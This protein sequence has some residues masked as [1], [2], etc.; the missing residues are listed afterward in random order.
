V[1][2]CRLG[3]RLDDLGGMKCVLNVCSVRMAR[4]NRLHE[5]MSLHDLEVVV[6]HSDAGRWLEPSQI[7]ITRC[8][9][10][11]AEMGILI[12]LVKTQL[13]LAHP[14]EVPRQRTSGPVHFDAIAA[15]LANRGSAGLQY[16]SSAAAKTQ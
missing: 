6:A 15:L 11:S 10:V 4:C 3:Q 16:S 2:V 7:T 13:Q 9:I 12:V 8:H 14:P 5:A 1:G